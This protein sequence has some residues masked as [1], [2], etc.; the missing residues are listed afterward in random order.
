MSMYEDASKLNQRLK[1]LDL[2]K[3]LTTDELEELLSIILRFGQVAKFRCR[4]N[5]A[6]KNFISSVYDGIASISEVELVNKHGYEF[7]GLSVQ[8][9]NLN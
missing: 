7:E 8:L 5:I 9:T 6:Y 2:A 1:A 4:S 3:K